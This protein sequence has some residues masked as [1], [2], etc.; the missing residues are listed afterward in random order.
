MYHL[1]FCLPT[2]IVGVRDEFVELY[3]VSSRVCGIFFSDRNWNEIPQQLAFPSILRSFSERR[4]IFIWRKCGQ[5]AKC[6]EEDLLGEEVKI[7][8]TDSKPTLCRLRLWTPN[9]VNEYH[10][11]VLGINFIFQVL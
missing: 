10:E 7:T 11:S 3:S 5:R 8:I 2:R 9:L 6:D 1:A 4:L